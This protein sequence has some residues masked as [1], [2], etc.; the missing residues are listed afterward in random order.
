MTTR[1]LAAALFV[2]V[3]AS[4]LLVACDRKAEDT[5]ARQRIEQGA[6]ERDL[7]LALRPDTPAHPIQL[8]DV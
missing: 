8:A 4:T 6:L 3:P 5:Q 7:D 1:K 2:A